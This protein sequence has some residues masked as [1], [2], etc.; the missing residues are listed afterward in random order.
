M[1]H[2]EKNVHHTQ[3]YIFAFKRS[4]TLYM[5]SVHAIEK[6]RKHSRIDVRLHCEEQHG[7]K[8]VSF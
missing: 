4:Q 1:I 6:Y 3:V 5:Y 2:I 7:A 8:I